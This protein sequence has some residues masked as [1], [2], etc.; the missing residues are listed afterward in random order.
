MNLNRTNPARALT[1]AGKSLMNC[2]RKELIECILHLSRQVV[3]AEDK[4][5][6]SHIGN[7]VPSTDPRAYN[8]E[9]KNVQPV[10]EANP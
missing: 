7:I 4:M 3:I 5:A 8:V 9:G 1:W 6:A 10:Q 2:S